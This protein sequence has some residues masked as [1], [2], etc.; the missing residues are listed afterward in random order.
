MNKVNLVAK[1]RRELSESYARAQAALDAAHE[2]AT[3]DDSLTFDYNGVPAKNAVEVIS[4][5]SG[6]K[7]VLD[8]EYDQAK[9]TL[10]VKGAPLDTCLEMLAV[11]IDAKLIHDGATY[12][13][14]PFINKK[15]LGSVAGI[16]GAGGNM[17][18]V[19]A[20]IKR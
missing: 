7:I 9:L 3:G 10:K 14:V 17:G 4:T 1:L 19:C 12:S 11:A 2:A 13:I 6:A 5:F 8:E 15:A 18:A 16:V 20:N